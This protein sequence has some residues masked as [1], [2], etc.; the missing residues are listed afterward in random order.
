MKT[1]IQTA[2]ESYKYDGVSF[3]DWFIDNYEM[4][5]KQEKEQIINSYKGGIKFIAGDV[6]DAAEYYYNLHYNQNK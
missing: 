6:D 5:L 3:T 1:A 2:F 4:L